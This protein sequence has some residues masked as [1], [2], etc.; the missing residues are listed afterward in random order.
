MATQCN[1]NWLFNELAVET[2]QLF[3]CTKCRGMECSCCKLLNTGSIRKSRSLLETSWR[4]NNTLRSIISSHQICG[5]FCGL[6]LAY[7]TYR[8]I[9]QCKHFHRLLSKPTRVPIRFSRY[10]FS[11]RYSFQKVIFE[12]IKAVY[13]QYYKICFWSAINFR[14]DAKLYWLDLGYHSSVL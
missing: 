11:A 3:N 14:P 7:A 13:R 10:W 9:I 2:Y 4:I 6:G 5:R 12:K 8:W 1:S